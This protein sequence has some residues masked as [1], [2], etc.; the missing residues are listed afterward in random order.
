MHIQQAEEKK[1]KLFLSRLTSPI[2]PGGSPLAMK[3]AYWKKVDKKLA[4][5]IPTK[6]DV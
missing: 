5:P 4:L 3:L 1:D 6:K 2:E